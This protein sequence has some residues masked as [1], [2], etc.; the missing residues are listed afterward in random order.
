M[1]FFFTLCFYLFVLTAAQASTYSEK[2]TQ[3]YSDAIAAARWHENLSNAR[4]GD[5]TELRLAIGELDRAIDFLLAEGA[6]AAEISSLKTARTSLTAQLTIQERLLTGFSP[7]FPMLLGQD[8][9]LVRNGSH[10]AA[11]VRRVI[12]DLSRLIPGLALDKARTPVVIIS[13]D[14]NS[15]AEIIAAAAIRKQAGLNAL[16]RV[17]LAEILDY[18]EL[19]NLRNSEPESALQHLHDALIDMGWNITGLHFL[20]IN[21]IETRGRVAAVQVDY[22]IYR[23]ARYEPLISRYGY[24][25]AGAPGTAASLL[26]ILLMLPT[27]FLLVMLARRIDTDLIS[28]EPPPFWSGFIAAVLGYIAVWLAFQGLSKIFPGAMTLTMSLMGLQFLLAIALAVAILP[29]FIVVMGATRFPMISGKLSNLDTLSVLLVGALF[30]AFARSAEI[31]LARFGWD[32]VSAPLIVGALSLLVLGVTGSLGFVRGLGRDK[33]WLAFGVV[34]LAG[35]GA[36]MLAGLRLE[37]LTPLITAAV[38]IVLAFITKL[39]VLTWER[40][41]ARARAQR[42]SIA[43]RELVAQGSLTQRLR[44][45]PFV[46]PELLDNEFNRII[47]SVFDNLCKNQHFHWI[48]ITGY[49]GSGKSRILQELGQRIAASDSHNP[50]VISGVCPESEGGTALPYAPFREMLSEHLSVARMTDASTAVRELQESAAATTLKT[51]MRAAGLN[52]LAGLI[53][54][55]KPGNSTKVTSDKEIAL[56][57]A[58]KMTSLAAEH[59]LIVLLDDLHQIDTGSLLALREL[60]T[61]QQMSDLSKIVFITTEAVSANNSSELKAFKS[62]LAEST[63][64]SQLQLEEFIPKT[65]GSMIEA[66]L[67]CIG[68]DLISRQLIAEELLARVID[69]PADILRFV[70]LAD[71]TGFLEHSGNSVILKRNSNLSIL[72]SP[73]D[74][75]SAV[76]S[77]TQGLSDKTVEIIRCAALQG[78]RF[79]PSIL[80]DIF[81][82]DLLDFLGELDEASLKGIVVDLEDCDDYYEFSDTRIAALFREDM[83]RSTRRREGVGI[84]MPQAVREYRRRYISYA[85]KLLSKKYQDPSF[86]PFDDISVIANHARFL[87]D[88]DSATAIRWTLLHGQMCLERGMTAAAQESLEFAWEAIAQNPGVDITDEQQLT[89]MSTLIDVLLRNGY[90]GDRLNDLLDSA[91]LIFEKSANSVEQKLHIEW[92][93]RG[94]EIYYRRRLFNRCGEYAQR[95]IENSCANML[96]HMRARFLQ[97]ASLPLD[98]PNTRSAALAEVIADIDAYFTTEAYDSD[99]RYSL[100]RVKAE[101]LNTLGMSVIHGEKNPERA[102]EIFQEALEINQGEEAPDGLGMRISLGGLGDS[103][104]TMGH[105]NEAEE[106]YRRNLSESLENDDMAGIVRMCSAIGGIL[107]DKAAQR[108]SDSEHLL[109]EADALYMRSLQHA[110]RQKN[111]IGQ[112]FALAGLARHRQ[113]ANLPMNDIELQISSRI[114]FLKGNIAALSILKD[115]LVKISEANSD[116]SCEAQKLLQYIENLSA[117]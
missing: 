20:R 58:K 91:E 13:V 16:G 104:L 59:H 66:L 32:W 107:L 6:S 29:M 95:V 86:A 33:T 4:G 98:N 90:Q 44:S 25:E 76:D 35:T 11:A 31:T 88:T 40:R 57:I 65:A 61:R 14:E 105:T 1:R 100:L 79:R 5:Q 77:L 2:S 84:A 64:S 69:H 114:E 7:L 49:S 94:A 111:A 55:A 15:T 53:D 101:A 62:E 26:I 70:Q 56:S 97:A 41:S 115:A 48:Q 112:A 30:G 52:P 22:G 23:G 60:I 92:H 80:A 81:G 78:T 54:G 42:Q 116:N 12:L 46:L 43:N 117:E 34:M 63:T 45:P 102:K 9:L 110:D 47:S 106:A 96:E 24:G 72:P 18:S 36:T 28:S 85:E 73:K 89:V 67:R 99:A 50:L 109:V 103:L 37:L 83:R 82:V 21:S 68:F 71:E 8:D 51:A 113:L 93:L 17:Q 38:V 39:I 87:T 3:D 75:C 74:A 10:E 19:S 108:N 27:Q